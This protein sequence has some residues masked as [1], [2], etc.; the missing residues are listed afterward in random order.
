ML[1]A[2]YATLA[3]KLPARFL[4]PKVGIVCGSGL[5]TLASTLR[6]VVLVSYSDLE[7]FGKSTVPGHKSMLAFGH[8]GNTDVPVVAMLGRVRAV[9]LVLKTV[10]HVSARLVSSM[11]TK[12]TH[13]LRSLIRLGS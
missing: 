9:S 7:G 5:S 11:R 3:S 1:D 10:A 12:A 8:M 4:H 6:D 2:T 13:C